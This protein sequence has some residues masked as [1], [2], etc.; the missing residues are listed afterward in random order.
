MGE[1]KKVGLKVQ[2]KA[3][4]AKTKDM[5]IQTRNG[6]KKVEEKIVEEAPPSPTSPTSTT[7][8]PTSPKS[9]RSV[10]ILKHRPMS[11]TADEKERYDA[12]G[13]KIRRSGNEKM[14]HSISFRDEKTDEPIK[15]VQEFAK[16]NVVFYDDATGL[17]N[18]AD[19][20]RRKCC[21]AVQ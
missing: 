5:K 1:D 10:G 2:G 9:A 17:D 16:I 18:G 21:C 13:N 7:R 4:E 15:E 14:T 8:T 12:D 11:P 20:E 19:L 3:K 6:G